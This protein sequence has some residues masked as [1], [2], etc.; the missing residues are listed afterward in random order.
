MSMKRGPDT[1]NSPAQKKL[2]FSMNDED[3]LDLDWPESPNL[4]PPH[5]YDSSSDSDSHLVPSTPSISSQLPS[6]IG[7][8]QPQISATAVA[9]SPSRSLSISSFGSTPSITDSLPF[10][11]VLEEPPRNSEDFLSSALL[12]AHEALGS[13]K[14]AAIILDSDDLKEEITKLILAKSHD[15]L[16]MSLKDSVLTADK[17]DRKYLLSLSP[18][19]LCNEM[20]ESAPQAYKLLTLGM[21]GIA[22]Q[23]VVL[24]NQHLMN[25][26]CMIY[27]TVAKTVNRKAS[28]YGLLLSAMARDGGLREDS[29]K[30]FSNFCHPRTVQKYDWEVLAKGWETELQDALEQESARFQELRIAENEAAQLRSGATSSQLEVAV[31]AVQLLRSELPNQVQLVWDNINL[32]MKH[33]FER[34][35]DQSHDSIYDWMASLWIKERISAN[36]MEHTPGLAL[37]KPSELNIQDFVPSEGEENYLFTGLV[38]YYASRL[39]ERH[40]HLFK[41]LNSSVKV[42]GYFRSPS[43]CMGYLSMEPDRLLELHFLF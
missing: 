42:R 6:E 36:H 32:R 38:H 13:K 17:K 19:T 21:F 20:K 35:K 37:K 23:D 24:D 9:S 2:E 3:K 25:N 40:P 11:N 33:K 28:G 15:E 1:G 10:P 39:T 16:K 7:I 12:S 4:S 22:D 27:S 34:Q 14:V 8:S 30:I 5:N 29:L 41:A 31:A 18:E 26:V 43:Q